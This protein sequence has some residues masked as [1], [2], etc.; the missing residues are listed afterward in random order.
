MSSD[1]TC[2]VATVE[3]EV[4]LTST[5]MVYAPPKTMSISQ[6]HISQEVVNISCKVDRCFPRT[7]IKIRV[8]GQWFGEGGCDS[9]QFKR[10]GLVRG[11]CDSGHFKM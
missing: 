11:G 6:N 4:S 9:G 3:N 10:K 8:N 7:E 1:Y 2:K 5:M